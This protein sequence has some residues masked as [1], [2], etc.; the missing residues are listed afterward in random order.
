MVNKKILTGLLAA[1]MVMS[2]VIPSFA[3]ETRESVNTAVNVQNSASILFSSKTDDP[4]LL[5]GPVNIKTQEYYLYATGE[6]AGVNSRRSPKVVYKKIPASGIPKD[7][8]RGQ[9]IIQYVGKVG[10]TSSIAK[11]WYYI[12]NAY[13]GLALYAAGSNLG[14]KEPVYNPD[15]YGSESILWSMGKGN[16]V[17]CQIF[18]HDGKRYIYQGRQ[19][20]DVSKSI[21]PELRERRKFYNGY[22]TYGAYKRIQES[23]NTKPAKP[24]TD[25]KNDTTPSTKQNEETT[26]VV[27]PVNPVEKEDAKFVVSGQTY[28]V[29]K[30]KTEVSFVAAKKNAKNIVIPATVTNKGVTY[31]VTSIAAKAVKAN[32]KVKKVTIGANVKKIAANAIFN[33]P[34]LKKVTIKSTMLTKKTVSKKAFKGVDKKMVIKVPKKEKKAYGKIFK[35]FKIK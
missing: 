14:L 8:K 35:G 19:I 31:K 26:V 17:D 29:T 4:A 3:A 12:I 23:G 9:W 20:D 16:S 25:K 32:K 5:N 34:N 27:N 10:F 33:C 30:A 21:L 11:N 24:S 2:S 28:K 13:N 15:K 18:N 7:D 22:E 6:S 1:T